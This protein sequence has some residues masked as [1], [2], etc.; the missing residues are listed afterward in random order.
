MRISPPVPEVLHTSH[1]LFL[2]QNRF[3]LFNEQDDIKNMGLYE[4]LLLQS[5]FTMQVVK[6]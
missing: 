6:Y 5:I 3:D 2:L 1:K 4:L